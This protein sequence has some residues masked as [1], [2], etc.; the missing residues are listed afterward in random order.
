MP[1]LPEKNKKSEPQIS[2]FLLPFFT[3][4]FNA[5]MSVLTKKEPWYR[6]P[7][8]AAARALKST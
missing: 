2:E 3:A 7:S 1:I 8:A 4:P 5:V 6:N